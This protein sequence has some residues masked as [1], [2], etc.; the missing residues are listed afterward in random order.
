MTWLWDNAVTLST[1]VMAIAAIAALIYAHLQIAENK[2]AERRANANEL[3]RETLRLAFD[4]PKLSDPSP[5]RWFDTSAFV[6]PARGSHRLMA[7]RR[8]IN[9][10]EA[11]VAEDCARFRVEPSSFIIRP[12]M[13]HRV[14]HLFELLTAELQPLSGGTDDPAHQLIPPLDSAFTAMTYAPALP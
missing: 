10:R 8:K 4:N 13:R 9:N 12:A 7:F 6:T 5:T 14:A 1:L 2:R 3:W 11:A